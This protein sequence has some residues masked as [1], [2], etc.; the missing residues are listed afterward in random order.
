MMWFKAT[1]PQSFWTRGMEKR[2][3]DQSIGGEEAHIGQFRNVDEYE[4]FLLAIW[5]GPQK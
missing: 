1:I 2:L 3:I 4:S 5:Q